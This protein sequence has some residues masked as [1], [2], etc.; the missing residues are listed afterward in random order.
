MESIIKSKILSGINGLVHGIST[1]AGGSAP[2]YNTLSRHVG[3]DE[4]AVAENRSRFFGSLGIDGS[5]LAHAN[6]IH[7]GSVTLVKS[8]GLFKET[9][10][11]ITA[12]KDL[13]LVISV[14]DCLP[15]MIYDPVKN[16][17]ANI[18]SG[19]RGTQKG[20]VTNAVSLMASEFSSS[21]AD[22]IVFI[23][24]GISREYFEVGREVAE[25]FDDKYVSFGD[26]GKSAKPFIDI[27]AVVMDQLNDA[28]VKPD[29]IESSGL[30]T[31]SSPDLLHSY[32]RD[33]ENSG[34]MFAV[35]GKR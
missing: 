34:R 8:P 28:G 16:V 19:W 20:I 24:P 6:Q 18:H 2:F 35:I 23:G 13:Y 21:P 12:E 32:R 26:S 5:R 4:S 31:Y 25:L 11:L 22:M 33:R 9:D 29:N 30:C 27:G 14:A 15:V 3:D 7:S 17:I 10:A 1:K